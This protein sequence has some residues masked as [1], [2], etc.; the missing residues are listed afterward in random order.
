MAK[1][2]KETKPVG[3]G[4]YEDD[5]GR[6]FYYNRSTKKAY[7]ILKSDYGK[8]NVLNSRAISSLAVGYLVYA[9]TNKLL[10]GGI[11]FVLIY[12]AM[13]VAFRKAFI[14]SSTYVDN[15]KPE[16]GETIITRIAKNTPKKKVYIIIALLFMLSVLSVVNVLT[17]NYELSIQ[18]L[19]YILAVV[20]FI[21][22]IIYCAILVYKNK[23]NLD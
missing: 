5:K 19:N 12:I 18:I 17:T 15:F 23:N 8:F 11:A 1:N 14:K 3:L 10:F 2:K 7:Q 4:V 20:A 22:A 6:F 16:K 13:Y 9:F 21:I